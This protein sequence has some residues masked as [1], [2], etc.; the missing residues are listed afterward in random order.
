MAVTSTPA[1]WAQSRARFRLERI[2]PPV[3]VLILFLVAWQGV[4]TVFRVPSYLVPTP[5]EVAQATLQNGKMLWAAVWVTFESSIAGFVLSIL[6]G[7]VSAFVMSQAKWLERSLYPYAVLLQT[8]PI[9]AIAP[10]IVI[11]AGSGIASII[12][13]SFLVAVFPIISNTNFGF[14]STDTNLV[15]LVKMYNSSRWTMAVKVRFPSALPQIFAGLKISAGLAVIG[16]IVGQFVAGIGGGNGGLGY[17]ITA[18]ADNL[19]MP[20]LFAAALASSLLGL[21][22]FGL[23]SVIAVLFIGKWHES[24]IKTD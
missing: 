18:T 12:V 22:N 2:G 11:W 8:I 9:V 13:I 7:I 3:L 23:V 19:Q 24:A 10:L 20:Y 16:A 17:L 5:V 15:S 21:F 4:C 1:L 6:V 14:L